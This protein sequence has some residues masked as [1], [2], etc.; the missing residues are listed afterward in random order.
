MDYTVTRHGEDPLRFDLGRNEWGDPRN[1]A[2]DHFPPLRLRSPEMH[3]ATVW[4]LAPNGL[5]G[6][7]TKPGVVFGTKPRD[8]PKPGKG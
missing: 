5:V 7:A 6:L 2:C 3:S 4:V 8:I 1:P